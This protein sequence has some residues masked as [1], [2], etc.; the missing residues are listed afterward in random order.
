M[1][2]DGDPKQIELA[3]QIQSGIDEI[4]REIKMLDEKLSLGNFDKS[5]TEGDIE[6]KTTESKS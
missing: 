6:L 4:L 2:K 1:I 3:K 5:D